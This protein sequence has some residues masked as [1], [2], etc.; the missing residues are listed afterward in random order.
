MYMMMHILFVK[1]VNFN[2]LQDGTVQEFRKHVVSLNYNALLCESYRASV[3]DDYVDTIYIA[4][5]ASRNRMC[6][7]LSWCNGHCLAYQRCWSRKV[8]NGSPL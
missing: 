2:V 5:L 1:L 8:Y 7:R 3:L 6:K 4:I